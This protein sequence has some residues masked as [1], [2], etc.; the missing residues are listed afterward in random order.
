[1][2]DST[3]KREFLIDQK[4]WEEKH[5]QDGEVGKVSKIYICFI[6]FW[7][8]VLIKG[9]LFDLAPWKLFEQ[10]VSTR[11]ERSL[12]VYELKA[13]VTS[14]GI[15]TLEVMAK[16]ERSLLFITKKFHN[17]TKF[18]LSLKHPKFTCSWFTRNESMLLDLLDFQ[19][20]LEMALS[21]TSG[22]EELNKAWILIV[23]FRKRQDDLPHFWLRIKVQF[24]WNFVYF[25]FTSV[26]ILI[27]VVR[28]FT[29][30]NLSLSNKFCKVVTEVLLGLHKLC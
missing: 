28:V 3:E 20:K 2:E 11:D 12:P 13:D 7:V 27:K 6:Q 19:T 21:V 10:S 4:I 8:Y 9:F 14:S 18:H 23:G 30:S 25:H 17:M 16:L 1:M 29:W 24:K 26:L 15:D 22:H 5:L